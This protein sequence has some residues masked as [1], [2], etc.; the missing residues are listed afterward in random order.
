MTRSTGCCLGLWVGAWLAVAHAAGPFLPPA[1]DAAPFHRDS[2]PIDLDTMS[3]LS[4]QLAGLGI[5]AA[6]ADR[7]S[8]R[9]AGAQLFALAEVLDPANRNAPESARQLAAGAAPTP[10][11]PAQLASARNHAWQVWSWLSNPQAGPAAHAFAACLGDALATID[12]GHPKAEALREKGEQG[13]WS[14]WIPEVAAYRNA[15]RAGNQTPPDAA[16]KGG[17]TTPPQNPAHPPSPA[18]AARIQL[19][20]ASVG[21]PLY[22]YDSSSQKTLS[23]RVPVKMTAWTEEPGGEGGGGRFSIRVAGV[24]DMQRLASSRDLLLGALKDLHGE[25]P[26]GGHASFSLGDKLSY[27][28]F[29]NQDAVWGPAAVLLHAALTGQ[30]PAKD[31]I[32]SGVI[33]PQGKFG[34]PTRPWERLRMLEQGSSGRLLVPRQAADL[35]PGLLVLEKPEYFLNHEVLVAGTLGE[36]LER[37]GTP[38]EG[39]LAEALAKFAEIRTVS[40]GKPT[41]QFVAHPSTR[42]RLTEVLQLHPDHMSARMLLLQGSGNRPAKFPTAILAREIRNAVKPMAWVQ[43][44]TVSQLDANKLDA[45]HASCRAVLDA[46]A[47]KVDLRDRPLQDQALEAVNGLRT[48][49]REVRRAGSVDTGNGWDPRDQLVGPGLRKMSAQYRA[50]MEKLDELTGED[51]YHPPSG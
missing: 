36:L 50:L 34:L 37:A 19:K 43:S 11:A 7:S 49:A 42:Q 17:Q 48:V 3:S 27:P 15:D 20:E 1:K 33:Q 29:G 2:L 21:A 46:L 38:T 6:R 45:T 9:R 44:T 23:G 24:E 39:P 35:L 18:K 47:T 8:R 30:A 22:Y 26:A 14:G 40:Q 16:D 28:V 5:E 32:V 31:V 41:A 12:P 25:L 10:P 13:Q 4:R 51:E